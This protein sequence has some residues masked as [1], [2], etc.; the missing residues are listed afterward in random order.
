MFAQQSESAAMGA[1]CMQECAI[2]FP[3]FSEVSRGC[4]FSR[5]TDSD[6]TKSFIKGFT[7]RETR[8]ISDGLPLGECLST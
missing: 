6:V 7:D 3:R 8:I 2:S 1:K 4:S 5:D